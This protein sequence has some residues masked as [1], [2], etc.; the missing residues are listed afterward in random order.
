MPMNVGTRLGSYEI[1]AQLG[2]GGPPPFA[3]GIQNANFG[4]ISPKPSPRGLDS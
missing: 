3:D 2:A 4:E 1:L